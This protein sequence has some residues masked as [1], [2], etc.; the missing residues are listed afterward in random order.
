MAHAREG[1]STTTARQ[2]GNNEC[3]KGGQ[4]YEKPVVPV[5]LILGS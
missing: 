3:E 4:S 2:T 5:V 1:S